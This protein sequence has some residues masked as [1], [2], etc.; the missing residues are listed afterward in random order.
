MLGESSVYQA[1]RQTD[2]A[3][4]RQQLEQAAE[5]FDLAVRT[6]DRDV[7]ATCQLLRSTANVELAFLLPSN[8]AKIA[9]LRQATASAER[10]S[11]LDF[12]PREAALISWGKAAEDLAY[13][14]RHES[15]AN[16]ELALS[17][18]DAAIREATDGSRSTALAQ[19]SAGRCRWRRAIQIHNG[20]FQPLQRLQLSDETQQAIAELSDAARAAPSRSLQAESSF[21][22]SQAYDLKA[23]LDAS[24]TDRRASTEQGDAAF[25]R[26]IELADTL[27]WAQYQQAW[28]MRALKQKQPEE[29]RRRAEQILTERAASRYLVHWNEVFDAL[30]IILAA[31]PAARHAQVISEYARFLPA[32]DPAAAPLRIRWFLQFVDGYSP[33]VGRDIAT[34]ADY[35][36]QAA[37]L[38]AQ[39][40][41]PSLAAEAQIAI[42]VLAFKEWTETRDGQHG[43]RAAQQLAAAM[44]AVEALSQHSLDPRAVGICYMY[45]G[46]VQWTRFAA[47]DPPAKAQIRNET[48]QRVQRHQQRADTPS[49][50]KQELQKVL[51]RFSGQ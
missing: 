21:F 24:D 18:F 26:A 11:Q 43:D 30:S 41:L 22:L 3:R 8:D 42:G 14:C 47:A 48:I 1:R 46:A 32:E 34:Y 15:A 7:Q 37:D 29:A 40:R 44:D 12:R 35:A 50:V 17:K 20:E 19:L 49:L 16:Y 4:R 28:A 31:T 36:Q 39:H 51:A 10:A 13:Y 6:N 9:R 38:A 5:L 33:G 45:Y 25:Q 27:S 2:P 23:Q